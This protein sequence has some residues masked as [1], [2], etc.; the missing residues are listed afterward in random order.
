MAPNNSC[1]IHFHVSLYDEGSSVE[2]VLW[3]EPGT[4]VLVPAARRHNIYCRCHFANSEA[5]ADADAIVAQV[6]ITSCFTFEQVVGVMTGVGFNGKY[7]SVN[8]RNLIDDDRSW[9]ID[10]RRPPASVI[11]AEINAW[12]EFTMAFVQSALASDE[13]PLWGL[14][15]DVEGLRS[16][17]NPGLSDDASVSELGFVEALFEGRHGSLDPLA[18]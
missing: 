13:G 14:T 5:L 3:I 12:A 7:Y 6:L 4:E 11:A 18:V 15:R 16:F 2:A 17:L 10:F 1:G 8:C 9:T